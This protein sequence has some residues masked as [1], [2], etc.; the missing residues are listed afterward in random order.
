MGCLGLKADRTRL[1]LAAVVG[2]LHGCSQQV[3]PALAAGGRIVCKSELVQ[4]PSMFPAVP[5]FGVLPTS[6]GFVEWTRRWQLGDGGVRA[7]PQP[8]QIEATAWEGSRTVA[9]HRDNVAIWEGDAIT[10]CAVSGRPVISVGFQGDTVLWTDWVEQDLSSALYTV[11]LSAQGCGTPILVGSTVGSYHQ[12]TQPTLLGRDILALRTSVA[13]EFDLVEFRGDGGIRSRIR[14]SSEARLCGSE[15]ALLV[16]T[17]QELLR[18]DTDGGMTTAATFA[19]PPEAS[20]CNGVGL[21][22]GVNSVDGSTIAEYSMA[23]TENSRTRIS[24]AVSAVGLAQGGWVIADNVLRRWD[25]GLMETRDTE[26]LRDVWAYGGNF[27]A[28]V[29]RGALLQWRDSVWQPAADSNEEYFREVPDGRGGTMQLFRRGDSFELWDLGALVVTLPRSSFAG[30]RTLT[31]RVWSADSCSG[32]LLLGIEFDG[33]H[34]LAFRRQGVWQTEQVPVASYLFA[35]VEEGQFSVALDSQTVLRRPLGSTG[36]WLRQ[37][38]NFNLPSN[39]LRVL[40]DARGLVVEQE[41]GISLF[42]ADAALA[43]APTGARLLGIS[44]GWVFWSSFE[45]LSATPLP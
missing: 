39:A 43:I 17:A 42:T 9:A 19:S 33:K 40:P 10:N 20:D 36:E 5:G 22:L 44:D 29:G 14:L 35:T 23:G 37:E 31:P 25:G 38:S 13:R 30:T 11:S 41:V 7:F 8:A 2:L 15:Q 1:A 45:R 26:V 4:I 12:L 24:G 28:S 6:D 3:A 27:M 21:V 18:F 34:A 16:A 32:D